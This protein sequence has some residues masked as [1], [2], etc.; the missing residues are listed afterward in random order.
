MNNERGTPPGE[1]TIL[2]ILDQARW[3]PSGDNTQPWRFEILSGQHLVVHGSDTR[4]TVVYD[5][6]GFASQ[7]ATG[8]L[9]ENITIAASGYGLK[10]EI[11]CRTNDPDEEHPLYDVYFLEDSTILRD[12]LLPFIESRCVNRRPLGRVP[13]TPEEKGLLLKSMSHTASL[14]SFYR[15][16][17]LENFS[18]K[19]SMARITQAS[20]KLRLV[21]PEAYPVHRAVI[22]WNARYSIDRIPDQALGL[23]FSIL[24]LMCWIM[25][26]WERV[27]FFNRFLGGTL[28][29]RLE[30]DIL[31]SLA[32]SAHFV[33]LAPV[34][35]QTLTD[36]VDAGRAL[37]R[38]WLGVTAQG[39]QFQP[40]MTPLIFRSYVLRNTSFSRSP[41][42]FDQAR[43]ISLAL[44]RLIGKDQADRA[45]FMGRVGRGNPPISRSLRLPLPSLLIRS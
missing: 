12:P 44:E 38:F 30:L 15:I 5:R 3:A 34:P 33:L 22:E 11:S 14:P 19:L 17:W 42:S 27:Q 25:G 24:P 23:S 43:K 29:P 10:A 40:E 16:L 35:P 31:P 21:I 6:S 20:G 45:V 39:L 7:I 41:S 37:C 18:A 2:R 13:L 8:A 36:Y 32:C 4:R 28:I 9:L 1:E 26:R